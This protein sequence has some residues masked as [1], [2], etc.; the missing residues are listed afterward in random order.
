MLKNYSILVCCF[1]WYLIISIPDFCTLTYFY[2]SD[3]INTP[4]NFI[5]HLQ[6]SIEEALDYTPHVILTGD[7]N[8]DFFS[9]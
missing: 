8:I 5:M 3:F 9:I 1:L 7:I 6:P 2:R 4:S